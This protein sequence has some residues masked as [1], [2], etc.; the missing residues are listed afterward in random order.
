MGEEES[1]VA[2]KLSEIDNVFLFVVFFLIA[3]FL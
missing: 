2:Q 3:V 1:E